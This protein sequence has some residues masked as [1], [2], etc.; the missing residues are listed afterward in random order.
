MTTLTIAGRDSR[1]DTLTIFSVVV[2]FYFAFRLVSV[3]IAVRLLDADPQLGVAASLAFNYLFLL[4][5]G[6]LSFGP[7]PRTWSWFYSVG[8]FRWS[9]AFLAFSGCSLLWTSSVSI[10]A[11][12]AFW[13]AMACD[14]TIVVLLLR[15]GSLEQT[16]SS[17]MHGYVWGTCAIGLEFLR[18]SVCARQG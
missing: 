18:Q 11:A 9:L 7:G 10:S 13:L 8:S 16:T 3:V 17:L 4:A 15:I 1:V 12:A 5:V 14:F 2:G 6:L